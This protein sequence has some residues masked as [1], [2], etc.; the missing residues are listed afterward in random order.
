MNTVQTLLYVISTSA[1]EDWGLPFSTYAPRGGGGSSLLYISIAYYMQKGGEGVQIACKI[2]YVL[3]GRPIQSASPTPHTTLVSR[4]V[5]L[6]PQTPK[7]DM[8]HF[9][10]STCSIGDPPSKTPVRMV[11][12]TTVGHRAQHVN[13]PH[14]SGSVMARTYHR[15]V[16]TDSLMEA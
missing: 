15:S 11:S 4:L 5:T 8:Y 2:A 12:C 16:S 3:N 6:W 7:I 14:K 9:L 1:L 13:D 10:N